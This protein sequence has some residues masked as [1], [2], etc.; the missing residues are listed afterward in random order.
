MPGE[1]NLG[2]S[3][4]KQEVEMLALRINELHSSVCLNEYGQ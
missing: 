1:R 4:G 3:L 2:G